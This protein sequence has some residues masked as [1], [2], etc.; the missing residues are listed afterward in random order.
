MSGPRRQ[1]FKGGDVEVV[2]KKYTHHSRRRFDN[3]AVELRLQPGSV[4][5]RMCS[6][7]LVTVDGAGPIVG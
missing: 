1:H 5:V 2:E 6:V 3:D 4:E 7:G